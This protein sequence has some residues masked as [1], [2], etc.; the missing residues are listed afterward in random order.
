[1]YKWKEIWV[2]FIFGELLGFVSPFQ[3]RKNILLKTL[4]IINGDP[5]RPTERTVDNV[6]VKVQ[7]F[8]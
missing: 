8:K 1:M 6:L 4:L 3:V 2:Y 5:L 7:S